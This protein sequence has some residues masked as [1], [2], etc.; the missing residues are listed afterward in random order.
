MS[1]SIKSFQYNRLPEHPVC[2]LFP[3]TNVTAVTSLRLKC[4]SGQRLTPK[5]HQHLRAY[6][7]K[8]HL[9]DWTQWAQL[10]WALQRYSTWVLYPRKGWNYQSKHWEARSHSLR[11]SQSSPLICH[12]YWNDMAD[13]KIFLKIIQPGHRWGTATENTTVPQIMT[14]SNP[15]I[16]HKHCL[17]NSNCSLIWGLQDAV[18][19]LQ[20]PVQL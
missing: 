12:H 18:H 1:H 9:E 17:P 13:K 7:F 20:S 4:R 11:N 10:Y 19:S 6:V 3:H 5:T 15:D 14:F 16:Q 8:L 2:I